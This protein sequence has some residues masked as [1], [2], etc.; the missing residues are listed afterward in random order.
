MSGDIISKYAQVLNNFAFGREHSVPQAYCVSCVLAGYTPG[1]AGRALDSLTCIPERWVRNRPYVIKNLSGI[2]VPVVY[3]NHFFVLYYDVRS[4]RVLV[5]DYLEE[6]VM[7]SK[8]ANTH[9]LTI[10]KW[11][12]KVGQCAWEEKKARELPSIKRKSGPFHQTGQIECGT[13]AMMTM[14][15]GVVERT[16]YRRE[17]DKYPESSIVAAVYSKTVILSDFLSGGDDLKSR[18]LNRSYE[19]IL[20][21]A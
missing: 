19:E 9:E 8:F 20:E 2:Y 15:A 3:S 14:R 1:S 18:S 6:G 21:F 13:L 16:L 4:N 7:G 11:F 5:Y 12:A 10:C 17:W